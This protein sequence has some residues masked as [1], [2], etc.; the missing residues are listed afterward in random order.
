MIAATIHFHFSLELTRETFSLSLSPTFSQL[1][2]CSSLP[3]FSSLLS[4]LAMVKTIVSFKPRQSSVTSITTSMK[5]IIASLAL[6]VLINLAAGQASAY[7]GGIVQTKAQRALRNKIATS[8]VPT[9]DASNVSPSRP[10]FRPSLSPPPPSR[11]PAIV[12][13]DRAPVESRIPLLLASTQPSSAINYEV[14]SR[15]SSENNFN[16]RSLFDDAPWQD[17]SDSLVDDDDQY[18][19]PSSYGGSS[20][21]GGSGGYGGTKGTCDM[22]LLASLNC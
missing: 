1:S 7:Y 14:V 21:G 6:S 18:Q 11:R 20:G 22:V 5:L 10:R 17:I 4:P 12:K 3:L 2:L 15:A 9:A 19:A 16:R 13:V 8:A